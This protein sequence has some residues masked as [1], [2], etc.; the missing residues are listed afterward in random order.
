[1]KDRKDDFETQVCTYNKQYRIF[2]LSKKLLGW[3]TKDFSIALENQNEKFITFDCLNLYQDLYFQVQRSPADGFCFYDAIIKGL[4]AKNVNKTQTLFDFLPIMNTDKSTDIRNDTLKGY[5]RLALAIE[6]IMKKLITEKETNKITIE[7]KIEEGVLAAIKAKTSKIKNLL[8]QSQ[9][10]LDPSE[11]GQTQMVP[12]IAAYFGTK[13]LYLKMLIVD[14][15]STQSQRRQFLFQFILKK[16]PICEVKET[17]LDDVHEI[18]ESY[19]QDCVAIQHTT[20]N[21]FDAL[22]PLP[23]I[24]SK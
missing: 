2:I 14:M 19:Y 21:H 3:S 7:H 23:I 15:A 24:L 17:V 8:L 5:Y 4:K 9:K 13:H 22:L 10:S 18:K 20:T 6:E 16:Y 11:W 12:L 1:M